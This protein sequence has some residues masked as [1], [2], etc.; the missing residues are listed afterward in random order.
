MFHVRDLG[1]AGVGVA[2]TSAAHNLSD[3][4]DA[5]ARRT[6]FQHL[7][8]AVGAPIA[9]VSQVHGC[10]VVEVT[11]G[12]RPIIDT[13]EQADALITSR[14]GLALAVRVADCIPILLT[15]AQAGWVAAVHA[16]R[17]GVLNGVVDATLEALTRRGASEIRAWLGP[18]IC[19]RCYEVPDALASDF[20]DAT[21]IAPA[22][23]RWGTT[24]IDIGAAARAQLD[25]AGV[26]WSSY[27]TCT[28]ESPHLHSFRRDSERSGRTAGLIWLTR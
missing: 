23:T 20:A 28:F 22:R 18:H 3:L 16:G 4:Q 10:R 24:G 27:E 12:K 8:D 26:G 9:V 1:T 5:S 7:S 14:T 21:G 25:A 15:D 6:A 11:D 17:A 19:G 13:G 2:F